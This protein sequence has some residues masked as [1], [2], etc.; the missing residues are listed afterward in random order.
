[1]SELDIKG[2]SEEFDIDIIQ[3]EAKDIRHNV[4]NI[5]SNSNDSDELLMENIK[6]ANDILDT[7][8][9]E[10]DSDSDFSA[11][12]MEVGALLVNSITNAIDKVYMK[13]FN[14]QSLHIKKQMIYLKQKELDLKK[15]GTSGREG[16]S[17]Q[18]IIITDREAVLKFLDNNK[19]ITPK[20][21]K[22]DVKEASGED[23]EKQ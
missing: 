14:S 6:K 23:D 16:V 2:L 11:R 13:N 5:N 21:L 8:K 7:L 10:V 3:E 20:M 17:S 18:N 1:M 4:S 19:N 22:N 9:E 12:T 15:L